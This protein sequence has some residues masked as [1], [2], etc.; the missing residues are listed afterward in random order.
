MNTQDIKAQVEAEREALLAS[1]S[2]K[3]E[4]AE[5]VIQAEKYAQGAIKGMQELFKKAKIKINAEQAMTLQTEI[6]KDKLEYL[7]KKAS[8]TTTTE[9]SEGWD[10]S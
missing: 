4:D 10:L 9:L 8:P 1:D 5:T 6:F 3:K 2:T 7:K